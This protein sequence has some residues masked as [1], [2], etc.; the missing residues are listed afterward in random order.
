MRTH[1][2]NDT[3][4]FVLLGG[5]LMLAVFV[6][7]SLAYVPS[8]YAGGSLVPVGRRL[9]W[10]IL[11]LSI[12][13][14]GAHGRRTAKVVAMMTGVMLLLRGLTVIAPSAQGFLI[15]Y[16]L[17]YS[18]IVAVAAASMYIRTG[19]LFDKWV[20][21]VA[22]VSVPVLLLQVLGVSETVHFVNTLAMNNARVVDIELSRTFLVGFDQLTANFTQTRPPGLFYANSIAA[23]FAVFAIAFRFGAPVKGVSVYDAVLTYM[24]LLLMAKVALVFLIVA[25]VVRYFVSRAPVEVSAV[26]RIA[27]MTVGL[28]LLHWLLFPGVV[29]D[30]L[31]VRLLYVSVAIRLV[32]FLLSVNINSFPFLEIGL[33]DYGE[34]NLGLTYE[35]QPVGGYSGLPFLT[36]ISPLLLWVWI[37]LKR[38]RRRGLVSSEDRI[39]SGFLLLGLVLVF[40]TSPVLGAPLIPFLFGPALVP[41]LRSRS[42]PSMSSAGPAREETHLPR[43][44]QVRV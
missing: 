42:S 37:R 11:A 16:R 1:R 2:P 6:N 23:I 4:P 7:T 39:R 30:R 33:L 10:I 31:S 25:I 38:A 34:L 32:D 41:M 12:V 27:L 26:R 35:G 20:R 19:R 24:T 22:Y 14:A 29:A 17:S 13:V 9:F 36:L 5:F 44:A 3:L 15:G 21:L 18:L 40:V 28:F 43:S 8:A